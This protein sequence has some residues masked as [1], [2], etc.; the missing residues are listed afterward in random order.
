MFDGCKEIVPID[1]LKGINV[2]LTVGRN[3]HKLI[4]FAKSTLSGGLDDMGK[5]DSPEPI[6]PP[7]TDF[8]ADHNHK[9]AIRTR[10]QIIDIHLIVKIIFFQR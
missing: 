9:F 4:V 2:D 3:G 10:L 7:N 1:P 6:G 8:P 5:D